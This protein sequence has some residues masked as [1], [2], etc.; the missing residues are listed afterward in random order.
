MPRDEFS[1][2]LRDTL[3]K[4]VSLLCS[5]PACEAQTTGPHSDPS[6]FIDVGVGCHITG[7]SPRGPRYDA[8]LSAGD[9]TSIDNAIWLCQRC[10]KLSDDDPGKYSV[11]IL[12]KWKIDAEARALRAI[13]GAPPI[14]YFPQP[15]SAAHAPIPRIAGYPYGEA[16]GLLTAAAWQPSRHHWSYGHQQPDLRYG[17]GKVLWDRGYWEIISASGTGLGHCYFG[18]HDLYGHKLRI[19]TVGELEDDAP[20]ELDV[21]VWSWAFAKPHD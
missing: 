17:N 19:V 11:T 8:S 16:R 15:P 5:N 3:S 7:A 2:G 4:R 18:F 12:R 20:P 6:S 1:H 14:D 9:R 10:A 21:C 13:A